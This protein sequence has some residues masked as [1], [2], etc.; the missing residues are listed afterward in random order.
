MLVSCQ[1]LEK[2]Q[3]KKEFHLVMFSV[4]FLVY[5]CHKGPALELLN[6]GQVCLHL[7]LPHF[8]LILYCVIKYLSR[9]KRCVNDPYCACQ[10]S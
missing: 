9:A 1:H 3:S 2:N 7:I 6:F 4:G 8:A 5:R 10:A